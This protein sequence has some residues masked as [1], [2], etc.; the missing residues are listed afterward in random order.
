MSAVAGYGTWR[1][2]ITAEAITAGQVG[3]AEPRLDG[4]SAYWLEARPQEAGRTVLV[5]R[6]PAG[7]RQDLTPAPFNVRTRVHEYGGGAYAVRDGGHRRRQL[8]RPAPLSDRPRR[9]AAGAD[10]GVR[11]AAA[12]RGSGARPGARP[13]PRG[14]RGPSR[15]RRGD[16]RD[17]RGASVRRRR[18]P[19]PDRRPR[20]LQLAP[21]QSRRQPARLAVLGSS[22][23][24]L[25]RHPACGLPKLPPT[26][27]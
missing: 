26:A 4:G 12:L 6:T 14:A 25:G 24:A 5:R 21:A 19:H 22:E 23:H 2:P 7:E 8:R 20:L 27:A 15:R 17:R 13:D 1:S 9:C 16:Q 18:G 11:R 10:A 3:L